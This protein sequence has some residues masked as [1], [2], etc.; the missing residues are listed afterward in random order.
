MNAL[1]L[2]FYPAIE[3]YQSD[4]LRVSPLH[5]L[6]YE[7]CGHPQGLPALFV[8]GGPG[9]GCEPM[10][11]RFFD[12]QTYRIILFDQRGAGRSQP[13]AELADNTTPLLRDVYRIRHL[14]R[15]II[16]GRYDIVCPARSAWDLHR[17]WP[18]AEFHLVPDA[19]HSA[20]EPGI[21]AKLIAAT[22]AF[23][24]RPRHH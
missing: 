13:L 16:Q 2:I 23:R 24:E 22:D 10:H 6:Y 7:Q 15:L 14:P 17:A 9:G 21:A 8:R 5:R 19:G 1:D 4:Y 3:P 20:T 11:R 12:P 18:E